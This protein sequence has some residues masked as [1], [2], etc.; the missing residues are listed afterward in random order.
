VLL[1]V[2]TPT[3]LTS[4]QDELLRKFAAARGDDVAERRFRDRIREAFH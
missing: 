1:K 3:S 4:E 2:E